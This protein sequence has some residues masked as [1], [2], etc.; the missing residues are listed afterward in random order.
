ME[1]AARAEPGG[2]W[3]STSCTLVIRRSG[4]DNLASHSLPRLCIIDGV[5]E[6]V[7]AK[8]N[9]LLLDIASHESTTEFI[10]RNRI[11][12]ASSERVK[13]QITW[14]TECL[15][16]PPSLTDRLLP[17]VV[18]FLLLCTEA[19]IDKAASGLVLAVAV[20]QDRPPATSPSRPLDKRPSRAEADRDRP[21]VFEVFAQ[22]GHDGRNGV[23]TSVLATKSVQSGNFTFD[24][25]I[26]RSLNDGLTVSTVRWMLI[27]TLHHLTGVPRPRWDF[28]LLQRHIDAYEALT[29]NQYRYYQFYAN[30]LTALTRILC[31]GEPVHRRCRVR[32]GRPR[33]F[34]TGRQP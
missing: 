27:D 25:H 5:S 15:D 17:V 32:G 18:I 13:D 9:I 19:G 4:R 24:N 30:M 34:H 14:F 11:R 8:D 20:D 6:P 16:E 10:R 12:E 1:A 26:V 28:S 22:G 21:D 2:G 33:F 29:E 23:S 31:Q 7:L 3:A